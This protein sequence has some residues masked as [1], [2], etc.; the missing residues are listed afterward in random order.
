MVSTDP[1][2]IMSWIFLAFFLCIIPL[3]VRAILF[4]NKELVIT[5][6][7]ILIRGKE[8]NRSHLEEAE[9]I[10]VKSKDTGVLKPVRILKLKYNEG[11]P[12]DRWM[13]FQQ[14]LERMN[15]KENGIDGRKVYGDRVFTMQL[16]QTDL[17]DSEINKTLK[18]EPGG[19]G[20]WY[21]APR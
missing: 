7:L 4:C 21:R 10:R 9:V 14:A 18:D 20:N 16:N 5:E 15:L 11:F 2:E 17:S 13:K 6:N 3:V 12:V 19:A 8:I 1:E